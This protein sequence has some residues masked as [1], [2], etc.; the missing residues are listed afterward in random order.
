[1]ILDWEV[2]RA[3]SEGGGLHHKVSGDTSTKLSS[4]NTTTEEFS[5]NGIGSSVPK[6]KKRHS[7]SSL[8]EEIKK[9]KPPTFDG[10]IK[11]GEEVVA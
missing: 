11:K 4:G 8:I 3:P 2:T 7:M 1:M 5:N 10:E 6:K 9:A